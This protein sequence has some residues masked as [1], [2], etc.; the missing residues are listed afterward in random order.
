LAF[1]RV[2]HAARVPIKLMMYSVSTFLQNSLTVIYG[3]CVF[4]IHYKLQSAQPNTYD[5]LLD[6]LFSNLTSK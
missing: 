3:F 4:Q 1:F 6:H 5:Q 2:L